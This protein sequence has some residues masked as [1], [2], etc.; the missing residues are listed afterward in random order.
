MT[1]YNQE[2]KVDKEKAAVE[3]RNEE[4]CLDGL[5]LLVWHMGIWVE[6]RSWSEGGRQ[7]KAKMRRMEG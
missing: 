5:V 3:Q 6:E 4:Q 1:F 7:K 2:R